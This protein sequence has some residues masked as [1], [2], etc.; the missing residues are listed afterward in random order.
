LYGAVSPKD[1]TCVYL[2]M[3]ASDTECFQVFLETLANKCPRQ[4]ILLC[5]D[6]AGNHDSS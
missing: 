6:G 3:P 1:G 4:L 2:I 5:V